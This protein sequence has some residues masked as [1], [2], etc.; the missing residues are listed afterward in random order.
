MTQVF[1]YEITMKVQVLAENKD[2][3]DNRVDT[4]GGYLAPSD[5]TVKLIA[6]TKL[7]EPVKLESVP[8]LKK[9]AKTK[10]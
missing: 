3:A 10:A 2:E 9:S 8:K 1:T 6:V 5:R 7:T 4:Q